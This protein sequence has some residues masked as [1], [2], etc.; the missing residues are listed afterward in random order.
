MGKG[1]ILFGRMVPPTIAA[2]T[3]GRSL[4]A[5]AKLAI[6]RGIGRQLWRCSTDSAARRLMRAPARA[7]F[8]RGP[9]GDGSG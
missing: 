3:V 1:T 4:V 7:C 9:G 5:E 6:A 2:P 8:G